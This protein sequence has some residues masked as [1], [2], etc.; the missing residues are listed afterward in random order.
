MRQPGQGGSLPGYPLQ[1]PIM[2]VKGYLRNLK[3]EHKNGGMVFLDGRAAFYSTIRQY[4]TGRECQEDTEQ[5]HRFACMLF[6]DEEDRNNFLAVALGPSLLETAEVP[7]PVRRMVAASMQRTWFSTGPDHQHIFRTQTGTMP[8][9]PLAD[10]LF[11]YT[12]TAFLTKMQEQLAQGGLGVIP[13]TKTGTP[14][15]TPSWMDDVALPVAADNAETLIPN[16][17]QVM[18]T[19]ARCLKDVGIQLNMA[20]GKTEMVMMFKGKSSRMIRKQWMCERNAL[21][22]VRMPQGH[23]E[24]VHISPTYLHLGAMA[25]WDATD[26]EDM[27]YRRALAR[28]AFR[29]YRKILYNDC[30]S[31]KERLDLMNSLVLARFMYAAGTWEHSR[32]QDTDFYHATIMEFYRR[33]FRPLTGYSSRNLTDDQICHCLGLL[34]PQELRRHDLVQTL[35]WIQQHGGEY[36]NSIVADSSWYKESLAAIQSIVPNTSLC[37]DANTFSS[38][39]LLDMARKYKR[40]LQQERWEGRERHLLA[41]IQRHGLIQDGCFLFRLHDGRG[42]LNA[43]CPHCG[44]HFSR[45][46]ALASHISKAHGI[47]ATSSRIASGDTCQVCLQRFWSQ[48]R[49]RDHLRRADKCRHAYVEAD[50]EDAQKEGNDSDHGWKPA[51]RIHGPQPWWATL[52]PQSHCE[53]QQVAPQCTVVGRVELARINQVLRNNPEAL[54]DALQDF[55]QAIVNQRAKVEDLALQML[56]K[57][58]HDDH[59]HVAAHLA[60]AAN[61]QSKGCCRRGSIVGHFVWP[62]FA[63]FSEER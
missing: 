35:A 32:K 41:V 44:L 4:F 22:E 6:E 61:V 53:E 63:I 9:A 62:D 27:K 38:T 57:S 10:L 23:C 31:V 19:A 49:L 47:T 24:A 50:M 45:N 55:M 25:A 37:A 36:L 8:G 34:T 28:E 33:V 39:F 26:L 13:V 21:C 14:A 15:P 20:R 11:Q 48:S 30:L 3:S 5:L 52:R 58:P 54:Q 12:F 2:Q 51:T 59:V 60:L 56:C 46:A 18:E 7:L 42:D 43:R 16:A 40:R 17:F 1:V 29:A